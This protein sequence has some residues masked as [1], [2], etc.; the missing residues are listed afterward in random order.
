[1]KERVVVRSRRGHGKDR[2][3][4]KDRAAKKSGAAHGYV[5]IRPAKLI[6]SR[7]EERGRIAV[8]RR[9]SSRSS[10]SRAAYRRHSD[11]ATNSS[12]CLPDGSRFA[13]GAAP[14]R[15]SPDRKPP[16]PGTGK[17][18]RRPIR[19]SRPALRS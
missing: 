7:G 2:A 19:R 9:G 15:R 18:P 10:S 12:E 5:R 11:G 13:R 8:R 14:K 17:G 1:M 6:P 16:K 4:K 3:E